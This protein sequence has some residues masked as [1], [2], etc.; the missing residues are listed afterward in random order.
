[1]WDTSLEEVVN[2]FWV[3]LSVLVVLAHV[4]GIVNPYEKVTGLWLV[5]AAGCTYPALSLAD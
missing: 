5:V 3:V 2:L 4:V 1:M